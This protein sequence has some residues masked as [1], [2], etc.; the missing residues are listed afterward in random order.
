MHA[1]TSVRTHSIYHYNVPR[2]TICDLGTNQV[3]DENRFHAAWPTP[4][5]I[6]GFVGFASPPMGFL[7]LGPGWHRSEYGGGDD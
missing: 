2:R 3:D 1:G 4:W 7:N 5:G 6:Y